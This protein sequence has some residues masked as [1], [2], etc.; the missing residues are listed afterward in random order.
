[1]NN[2][3]NINPSS[4]KW[5]EKD[6][7]VVADYFC[8]LGFRSLK[9]ILDMRVF[10]LMNMQGLNAVRVEEVIIC[11]YKWLNP[12]TAIDEAMILPMQR[13][14]HRFTKRLSQRCLITLR[15]NT[16]FS[17]MAGYQ[18]FRTGI[19]ATAIF[20]L[21]G[22]QAVSNGI[23]QDGS[24]V[25]MQ[26]RPQMRIRLLFADTGIPRMAIANTNTSALSLEKMRTSRPIMVPE[27]LP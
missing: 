7:R 4:T 5:L 11:L 26:H 10:D 23:K 19:K 27:L 9:Q 18:A 6:D 17:R 25:W 1:M 8:D 3:I 22:K 2:K 24:M 16:M 12:N 21:G 14:T 13:K 15:R 20:L